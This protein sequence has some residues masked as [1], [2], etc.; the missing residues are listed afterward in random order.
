MSQQAP[1][2]RIGRADDGWSPALGSLESFPLIEAPW[3]E[4]RE[5]LARVQPAA[6]LISDPEVAPVDFIDFAAAIRGLTPYVPLLALNPAPEQR[7]SN[8]IPFSA[9]AA[10]LSRLD[11]R[12]TAALRVR[13]L[14]ATVLRRLPDEGPVDYL[15]ATDPLGDCTVLLLGRGASYPQLSIALGERLGVIGALSIEAAARHLNARDLDGIVVGDGF[16]QRVVEAFLLVLAEDARFRDLP[17]VLTGAAS[18]FGSAAPLANLELAKGAPIDVAAHSLGLFRQHALAARLE[19]ALQSLDA[20]GLLDP[21]TGLLTQVAFE[22]DFAAAVADAQAQGAGFSA[23]RF[24]F[25]G[26][27]DRLLFDAARMFSRLMRRMDFAC[28]QEDGSVVVGFTATDLRTAHMVARRLASVL[29]HTLHGLGRD[30]RIDPHV[31]LVTLLPKDTAS[32]MRSRLDS[33]EPSRE[34]AA[35]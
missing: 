8:L 25:D 28:L 34:A 30:R 35:S 6:V 23:A 31:T 4:A 24:V 27:H 33:G 29:R 17:V 19:R 15:P 20:G 14:H 32:A 22:K 3:S 26:A 9:G 12:I 1:I 5:A 11:A 7:A 2:L 21:R 16:S 18:A 13:T 10:G